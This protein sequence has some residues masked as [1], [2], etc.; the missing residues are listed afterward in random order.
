MEEQRRVPECS[1]R[2]GLE[3]TQGRTDCETLSETQAL[4]LSARSELELIRFKSGNPKNLFVNYT[5]VL[6]HDLYFK[7]KFSF[8]TLAG[9]PMLK[10]FYWDASQH[11]LRDYD[12]SEIR[13]IMASQYE[14]DNSKNILQAVNMVAHH[15]SYNPV[16]RMLAELPP[17][18]GVPR[19]GELFPRYLGAERSEYVAEV[20]KIILHGAIQRVRSPGVKFDLCAIL[21]DT[22]QGTG[23]STMCRLLA[24]DDSFFTDGLKNFDDLKSS[25][26]IIRGHWVVELGEMLAT[27][28]TK[29]IESIKSYISRTVDVYRTPY[30]T[31][32]ED[33]PR[34][35]IFIGTTNRT[36][37]LPDDATGN[38]RFLPVICDGSKAEKHPLDDVEETKAFIRQCYA[39]ALVIGERDGWTLTIAHRF[40]KEVE[41][42]REA[43]TPENTNVGL[44][45]AFLD[46]PAAGDCV[47]SRMIWDAIYTNESYPSNR[48]P[49][50]AELQEISEI[51]NLKVTGWQRH[52][53]VNGKIVK[54]LFSSYGKQ[55]AWD[56]IPVPCS[57][58][59]SVSNSDTDEFSSVPSTEDIPF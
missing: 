14:I 40:D 30:G 28:R 22:T 43:A 24:L 19:L 18:D 56:R 46:K 7:G 37:F 33:L 39:E 49:T 12:L 10:G 20:T 25:F 23:K 58:P 34:Q 53:S 17:W 51:M 8:N 32:A 55:L 29:D 36:Q 57:V 13:N 4:E 5:E 21:A 50:R 52:V 38:R 59:K 1:N 41:E 35:C 3:E 42:I 9:R 45:Q 31:T 16:E 15:D 27:R 11:P 44:I 2:G 48:T 54:K 26:E 6:E 47:C